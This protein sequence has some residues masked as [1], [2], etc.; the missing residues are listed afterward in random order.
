[1]TRSSFRR[2]IFAFLQ[3]LAQRAFIAGSSP[4]QALRDPGGPTH[5][6]PLR[7][8]RDDLLAFSTRESCAFADSRQP[9]LYRRNITAS[10]N[11]RSRIAPQARP[12]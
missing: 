10:V 2:G 5:R 12:G 9:Y 11:V 4:R 7:G 3:I 6:L 1:M 8:F